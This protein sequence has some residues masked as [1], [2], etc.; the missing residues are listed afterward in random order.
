MPTPAHLSNSRL[1]S[2]AHNE[3]VQQQHRHFN[4]HTT[5]SILHLMLIAQTLDGFRDGMLRFSMLRR[6]LAHAMKLLQ[7]PRR[8]RPAKLGCQH[9]NP[10]KPGKG[11][12][13][14]SS[15]RDSR[16]LPCHEF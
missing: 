9:C 4:L 7:K 16:P 15:M 8:R 10:T 13:S 6:T 11:L 2:A 12:L 1:S 14:M 3:T 5:V